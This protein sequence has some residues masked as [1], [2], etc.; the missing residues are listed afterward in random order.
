MFF[1]KKKKINNKVE[2][3]KA[4]SNTLIED[5]P[6][7]YNW[8]AHN[9]QITNYQA[10]FTLDSLKDID[11]FIDE[12]SKPSG[13]FNEKNRKIGNILFSLGCYV[14]ETIK[15]SYSGIWITDDA[16]PLGEINIAVKLDNGTLFWPVQRVMKRYKDGEENAIYPYALS[17]DEKNYYVLNWESLRKKIS[18]GEDIQEALKDLMLENELE[19][20]K[21]MTTAKETKTQIKLKIHKLNNRDL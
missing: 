9:L 2:K 20:H 14:G 13:L 3:Q 10:D 16:D 17:M 18:K 21:D 1:L 11:R 8:A 19:E 4:H 7:A 15:R 12:Q 5:I 6:I